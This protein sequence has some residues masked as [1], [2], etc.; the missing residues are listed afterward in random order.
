MDK[1]LLAIG[2]TYYC[3]ETNSFVDDKA[4]AKRFDTAGAA[5][6]KRGKLYKKIFGNIAIIADHVENLK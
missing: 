5:S 6:K 2:K 3:E 4:R 1:Y